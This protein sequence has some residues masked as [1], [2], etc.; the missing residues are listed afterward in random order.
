MGLLD[1]LLKVQEKVW[2]IY[3]N[4]DINKDKENG[5]AKTEGTVEEQ[6]PKLE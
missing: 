1:W 4:K 6:N 3:L 2:S 5:M